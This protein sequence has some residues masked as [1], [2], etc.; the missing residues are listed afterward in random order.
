MSEKLARLLAGKAGDR[1]VP[2][3]RPCTWPASNGFSNLAGTLNEQLHDRGKCSIF[4]RHDPDRRP[5]GRELD[6][7]SFECI[8]FAEGPYHRGGQQSYELTGS[9]ELDSQGN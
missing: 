3:V 1:R 9:D 2:S 7:Q 4:Q 8:S 6:R 5:V